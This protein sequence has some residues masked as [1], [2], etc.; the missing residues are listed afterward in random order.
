[1]RLTFPVIAAAIALLLAVAPAQAQE[2]F[3]TKASEALLIDAETGAVLFARNPDRPVPP[4]ALAKLM[5]MEVVFHAIE[6]GRVNL[7]DSFVVSENAWRRGG[8]PSGGSTMFAALK[9]SIRLEDLVQGVIVQ[10]ANDGCIIIAEGMAGDEEKFAALMN[11]RAQAIGLT[12]STF[13]NSS[14]LPAEGQLVTMRDLVR[15]AM[16]LWRAYPQFYRYYAQ[17]EFTWNKIRQRNRNPLLTMGIGADG[18]GTGYTDESGYGIVGSASGGGRRVFV[19]MSG[20]ESDRQRADEA[21]KLLEGGMKAF[22]EVR[23]FVPDEIVGTA[24]VYGGEKAAVPLRADGAVNV[25]VPATD[26]SQVEARIVY[27]GPVAAP[28]EQGA[29]IGV[30]QVWLG[31]T[32]SQEVPLYAAET[33]ALGAIH[34]RAMGAVAELLTGWMR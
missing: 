27:D 26:R 34:Q 9:S 12:A 6:E 20:M 19:A 17:P 15:L 23:L 29:R 32:L 10:S 7:D 14:G 1:M 28:V 16:H 33:V 11:E 30:L 24:A 25:L 31:D 21:R 18:L 13:R 2:P 8:A 22:S 5:T 3:E 4:A